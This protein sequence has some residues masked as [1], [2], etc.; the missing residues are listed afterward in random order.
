MMTGRRSILP[1]LLALLVA[2]PGLRAEPSPTE[3]S[4]ARR[5]FN[6]A[7]AFEAERRW[8]DARRKL[9]EA[10]AIK[11]TPGLRFHLGFCAEQLGE[12]VAALIEY[13]RALDL[14][15]G[16]VRAPDVERLLEPARARV[17][18][19]VAHLTVGLP[20]DAGD[21]EVLLDGAPLSPT[22][23]AHPAPV[24]PGRHRLRVTASDKRVS[25]LQLEL[26]DGERRTV[27]VVFPTAAPSAKSASAAPATAQGS[28]ASAP[29]SGPV[30]SDARGALGAREIV[31]IGEGTAALVGLAVGVGFLFVRS[32]AQDRIERSQ[33][34]ID[35]LAPGN[36]GACAMQDFSGRASCDDLRVA[37]DDHD[38]AGMIATLGFVGAGVFG[39]AGVLT[40]VLWTNDEAAVVIGPGPGW[41]GLGLGGAF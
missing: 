33:A 5:L 29:S 6:E 9:L 30:E 26:E 23:L 10:I 41:A 25:E 19:R 3:L 31:L 8:V 18:G 17:Q 24:D 11:E 4:V 20:A 15:R 27:H 40:A 39:V 21:A 16:G 1:L 12:L 22:V 2:S 13:E 38:R 14:I 36:S 37:I 7:E 32:A 35:A 34:E 28:V